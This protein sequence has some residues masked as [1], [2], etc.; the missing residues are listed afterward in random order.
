MPFWYPNRYQIDEEWMMLMT[1]T[2]GTQFW[3]LF[4]GQKSKIYSLGSI[5]GA[6]GREDRTNGS[7]MVPRS[8][9]KSDQKSLQNKVVSGRRKRRKKGRQTVGRVGG[10][11]KVGNGQS[12]A[13][14]QHLHLRRSISSGK[15]KVSDE[16]HF[17]VISGSS[18][19]VVLLLQ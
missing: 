3:C 12:P 19:T 17:S 5:V 18:L 13:W 10:E 14:E 16:C 9:P 2:P 1:L 6:P 11:R 4:G 15:H 8:G 7:I